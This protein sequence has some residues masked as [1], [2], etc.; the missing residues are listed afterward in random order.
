MSFTCPRC[1]RTSHHPADAQSYYCAA[2]KGFM[3]AEHTPTPMQIDTADRAAYE[4]LIDAI[5]RARWRA[6]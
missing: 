6:W 3:G 5:L 2:C 4:A 1:G